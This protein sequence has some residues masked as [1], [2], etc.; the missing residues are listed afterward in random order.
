MKHR[1]LSVKQKRNPEGLTCYAVM[2]SNPTYKNGQPIEA[3]G[4]RDRWLFWTYQEA[5]ADCER[6]AQAYKQQGIVV[7]IEGGQ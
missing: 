6:R 3:G 4:Y 7:T 1:T 2:V 5:L